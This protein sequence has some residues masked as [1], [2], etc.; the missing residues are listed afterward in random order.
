MASFL[1]PFGYAEETE[2]YEIHDMIDPDDLNSRIE[3]CIAGSS[4]DTSIGFYYSQT[5]EEFYYNADVWMYSASLYKV[6]NCM[7]LEEKENAGE[8]TQDTEI[9]GYTVA[10]QEYASIVNSDNDR[11][12]D[13]VRYLGGEEYG[14]KCSD[15]F[16]KYTD[17]SED[18]FSEPK[19]TGDS[20]YTARFYNK[21]LMYLYNHTDEYPH[22]VDLMK[23]TQPNDYLHLMRDYSY[24]IAQKYGEYPSKEDG[25]VYHAAGIIYT[26]HP[27]VVTVMTKNGDYNRQLF[28]NVANLLVSYAL[29]L[30]EKIDNERAEFEA[31]AAQTPEPTQEPVEA[32]PEP[33][34]TIVITPKPEVIKKNASVLPLILVGVAILSI[35]T[36]LFLK[37][38]PKEEKKQ[39]KEKYKPKH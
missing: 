23:Q 24:E 39:K 3:Y 12:H 8:I 34:P 21:I 17:L 19:F 30:D 2:Q 37:F 35:G 9:Y 4:G 13:I 11:G 20:Y 29:E 14:D 22:V 32:T 25:A 6:P 27:I 26:P 31:R 1:V 7:L 5:G 33:A 16:I 38:K 36:L 15:R 10:Q 18:Y 28:G